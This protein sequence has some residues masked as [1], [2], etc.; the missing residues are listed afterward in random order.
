MRLACVSLLLCCAVAGGTATHAC[1]TMANGPM[2][3][4]M[5]SV[6]TVKRAAIF[7]THHNDR[8]AHNKE[9]CAHGPLDRHHIIRRQGASISGVDQSPA[10]RVVVHQALKH[11]IVSGNA[12]IF[13]G[14]DR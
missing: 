5:G 4:I 7:A 10:D 8:V 6:Q 13:M 9:A 1:T 14:K 12:L 3:D 2:R 11:L